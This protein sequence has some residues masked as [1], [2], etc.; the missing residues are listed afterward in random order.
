[1]N[2]Q[3]QMAMQNQMGMQ[4]QMAMQNQMGNPMQNQMGMPMPMPTPMGQ[5]MMPQ[6]IM[7]VPVVAQTNVVNEVHITVVGNKTAPSDVCCFVLTIVFASFCLFPLLFMCCAWWK[8][9]VY[10]KYDLDP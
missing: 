2:M 6:P 10:P 9:M 4:N 5:M 3:N 7:M 8:K 1:M